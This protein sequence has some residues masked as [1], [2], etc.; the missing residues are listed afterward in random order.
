MEEG[1]RLWQT[2]CD[3]LFREE[4]YCAINGGWYGF[5]KDVGYLDK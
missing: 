5:M 1:D 3:Q 2:N 4:A